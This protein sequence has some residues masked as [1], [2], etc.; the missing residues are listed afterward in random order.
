MI[1]ASFDPKGKKPTETIRESFTEPLVHLFLLL[2][3]LLFSGL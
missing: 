2:F 1:L 3:L